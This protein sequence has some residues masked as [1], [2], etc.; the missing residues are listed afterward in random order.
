[1]ALVESPNHVDVPLHE[2]DDTSSSKHAHPSELPNA[3]ISSDVTL[4]EPKFVLP[5][6][7]SDS[8]RTELPI[9]AARFV[10]AW[11]QISVQNYE[12]FLS[13]SVGLSWPLRKVAARI[14]PRPTWYMDDAAGT[15]CCRVDML[16]GA[17]KS[18]FESYGGGSTSFDEPDENVEGVL[19]TTRTWWEDGHVLCSERRSEQQNKGRAIIVRRWVEPVAV[20]SDNGKAH[21]GEGEEADVLVVTQEWAPGK[22][23]TQRLSRVAT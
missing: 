4:D 5:K 2:F 7:L 17:V 16:G 11:Q 18:I 21:E 15:L 1:M 13:D 10:G 8:S 19:W 23:F 20:P 3:E 9:G 22:I 14:K 6:S 12:D